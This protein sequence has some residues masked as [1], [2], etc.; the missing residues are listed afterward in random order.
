[1][2]CEGLLI[3]A[4]IDAIPHA[5]VRTNGDDSIEGHETVAKWALYDEPVVCDPYAEAI[6][7]THEEPHADCFQ[8][9]RQQNEE[10]ISFAEGKEQQWPDDEDAETSA[11]VIL[12][13][14][15]PLEEDPTG[16]GRVQG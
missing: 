13:P 3:V 14:R 1:M 16:V 2:P 5:V 10:Y 15:G 11:V 6:P 9:D 4:S 7:R 12:G 8:R